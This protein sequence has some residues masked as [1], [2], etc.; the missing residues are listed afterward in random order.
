MT[1]KKIIEL[2]TAYQKASKYDKI[3]IMEKLINAGIEIM[4]T[5]DGVTWKR[6][7]YPLRMP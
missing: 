6:F 1:E 4:E 3:A 7:Q 5:K 2:V